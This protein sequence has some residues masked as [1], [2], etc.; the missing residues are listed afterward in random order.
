[1][2]NFMFL[3]VSLAGFFEKSTHNSVITKACWQIK[4]MFST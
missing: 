3:L 2:Q 4:V 1:M